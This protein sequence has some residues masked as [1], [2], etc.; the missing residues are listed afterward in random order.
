MGL[1]PFDSLS[2][3]SYLHICLLHGNTI[4]KVI[5]LMGITV[6]SAIKTSMAALSCIL[7]IFNTIHD[8]GIIPILQIKKQTPGKK[9]A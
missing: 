4:T 5:L 7:S 9:R 6:V 2:L 3:V 8:I 1:P